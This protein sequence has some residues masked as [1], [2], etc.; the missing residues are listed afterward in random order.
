MARGASR[1]TWDTPEPSKLDDFLYT[2]QDKQIDLKRI[3]QAIKAKVGQIAD[4]WNP[5]LQEELYHG[6]T[7]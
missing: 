6:R 7:A 1:S 2:L 3:V 4:R 5:Y